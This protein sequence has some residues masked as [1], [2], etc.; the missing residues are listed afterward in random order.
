MSNSGVFSFFTNLN[1]G[2]KIQSIVSIIIVLM[3]TVAGTAIYQ[4]YK[5]GEELTGIAERDIPLTEILSKITTHQLE[6]SVYFERAIRFGE[7]MA[8]EP[9]AREHFATAT[10][11]F[12]SLAGKVDKEIKEGEAL[13]ADAIKNAVTPYAKEEFTH[14]LSALKKIEKAHG[15][16]DEH[17]LH[18]LELLVAGKN[19]E[20][21]SLAFEVEAEEEKLNHELVAL[22]SEVETFTRKA[23]LT[24]EEHEKAALQMLVILSAVATVLGF[25]STIFVVRRFVSAPL[26]NTVDALN[27]LAQG[28]TSVDVAVRSTDEIGQVG[29]AF[30]SFKETTIE[31]QRLK[32]ESAEAEKRAE[33]QRRQDLLKMADDLE[34][35]VKGVV[36]SIASAAT[37]MQS[38]AQGMSANAEQTSKQATAV[39]AASEEASTNVQTVAAAAEELGASITEISRQISDADQ[40]V[41]S[42]VT[43]STTATETVSNLS[44]AAGRIGEV[45][46]LINDIAAQ[47]NL[48][49]L[50]ATIEAARA[51]EAGKGF[52][53]VASEVKSLASQT[54]TATEEIAQQIGSIQGV[55]ADTSTAIGE[56][57]K[58]IEDVSHV[59][60]AV[61]SAVEEQSAATSEIASN[62]QQ[63]ARGTQE[64]SSTIGGVSDAAGESGQSAKMVLDATG[65]LSQQAEGLRREMDTFLAGLRAA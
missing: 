12:E 34:N 47:T 17:A 2:T 53:V 31:A 64:V 9:A 8:H 39:A 15:T 26:I 18:V 33:E 24:A 44:E 37:E 41:Q 43:R 61:A 52:A 50:N 16:F 30:Q 48:L 28:D 42:A 27:A 56:I 46:D 36:E 60:T 11:H 3:I 59:A 13:A 62:V 45:V 55:V 65:E 29:L 63:A 35:S 38:S 54:G 40:K 1:V 51:G 6:Q 49:A 19:K 7:E 23:A 57:R 25:A 58:E 21:I 5:I 4:I 10:E 14:V 22:L 32:E 20:A